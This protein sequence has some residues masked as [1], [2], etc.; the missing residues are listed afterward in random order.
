MGQAGCRNV[1]SFFGSVSEG[2]NSFPQTPISGRKHAMK[3]RTVQKHARIQPS[4]RDWNNLLHVFP[5]LKRWAIFTASLRDKPQMLMA[6]GEA[7][8]LPEV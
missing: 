1:I 2:L 3:I 8:V 5:T 6:P 4:L 7:P